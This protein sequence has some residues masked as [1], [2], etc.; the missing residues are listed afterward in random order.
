MPPPLFVFVVGAV[1]GAVMTTGRRTRKMKKTSKFG[2][3]RVGLEVVGRAYTFSFFFWRS[4]NIS[5]TRTL[6]PLPKGMEAV[7]YDA[8]Y[9]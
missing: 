6:F 7:S 3:V 8:H 1:V 9:T 5:R 2:V 4:H